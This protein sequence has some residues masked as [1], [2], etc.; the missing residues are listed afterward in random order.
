MTGDPETFKER[1]I[2][3]LDA[4]EHVLD[5]PGC[6]ECFEPEPAG[7]RDRD[8]WRHEAAEWQKLK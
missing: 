1:F 6:P 4:L 8:E 2:A 3:G 5:C 7:I